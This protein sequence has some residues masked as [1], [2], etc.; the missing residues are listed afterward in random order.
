MSRIGYQ[1]GQVVRGT[2]PDIQETHPSSEIE[3][4]LACDWYWKKIVRPEAP[5]G[6]HV[7]P[8]Q[9]RRNAP[10]SIQAP[11]SDTEENDH[12]DVTPPDDIEHAEISK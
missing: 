8:P 9:S 7:Q 3:R 10:S 1:E 12:H 6:S 2:P 11:G 4:D 5:S